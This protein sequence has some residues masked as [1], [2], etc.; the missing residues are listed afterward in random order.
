MRCEA[1][2]AL[3]GGRTAGAT[4]TWT[5]DDNFTHNVTFEG[6]AS[7]MMWPGQTATRTFDT[8]GTYA[9]QCTL[10]PQDMQVT[11]S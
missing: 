9:C 7:L 4:V 5:N 11:G 3:E 10:H 8:P 2:L 1:I 6:E